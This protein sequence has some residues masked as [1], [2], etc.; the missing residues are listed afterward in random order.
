MRPLAGDAPRRGAGARRVRRALHCASRHADR[1]KDDGD[2]DGV[3][4]GG[5][6]GGG[7]GGSGLERGK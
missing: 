6:G 2:G 7:D 3:E 1:Y 4:G 5:G